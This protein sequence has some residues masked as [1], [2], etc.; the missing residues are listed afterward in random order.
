MCFNI[1]FTLWCLPLSSKSTDFEGLASFRFNL[2]S[3]Y[4]HSIHAINLRQLQQQISA[5]FPKLL[6]NIMH[7][8]FIIRCVNIIKKN[9][10]FLFQSGKRAFCNHRN[11]LMGDLTLPLSFQDHYALVINLCLNC[12][13]SE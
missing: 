12:S 3:C 13:C 10:F 5:S 4:Y 11:T 2:L 7:I 8:F 9:L 6:S 1:T